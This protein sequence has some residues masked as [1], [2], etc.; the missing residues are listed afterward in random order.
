[1]PW[2]RR[3]AR[4]RA[5]PSPCATATA[6][7]SPSTPPAPPAGPPPPPSRPRSSPSITRVAPAPAATG[8]APC[9]STTRRSSYRG[10]IAPSPR[11][12]RPLDEATLRGPA[13]GAA[14]SRAREGYSVRSA[15]AGPDGQTAV[16]PLARGRRALPR[17]LSVPGAPRGKALQAVHPRLPAAVPAGQDLSRLRGR[18]A[19]AG[20]PL[21]PRRGPDHRSSGG[22]PRGRARAVA[23]GAAVVAV[24]AARRGAHPARARRARRV[25]QRRR[26]RVSHARPADPH[27]LGRRSAADRKSVV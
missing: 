21:G 7:A 6:A 20:G 3:S 5:P 11:G 4:A 24:P 19:Q 25:R 1:M 16:L 13:P 2:R 9:W 10:P 26:P 12:A 14:R 15:V 27:A 22:A 8:S 23:G 18:P 17:H